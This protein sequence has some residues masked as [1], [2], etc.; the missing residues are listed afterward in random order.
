MHFEC[1]AFTG[2]NV[3]NIFNMMTKNIVNKV[4]EGSIIL[5][6]NKIQPNIISLNTSPQETEIKSYCSGNC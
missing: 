4:E 1:S 5:E 6:E 2:E 3:E